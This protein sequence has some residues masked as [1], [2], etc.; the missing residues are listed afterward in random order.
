VVIETPGNLCIRR[1]F[2][3]EE[4]RV[5]VGKITGALYIGIMGTKHSLLYPYNLQIGFQGRSEAE[6]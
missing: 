6:I 2:F 5:F 3:P 4:L 1:L